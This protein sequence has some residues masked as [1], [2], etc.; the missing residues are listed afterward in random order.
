[1]YNVTFESCLDL[2]IPDLFQMV[3]PLNPLVVFHRDT[4]VIIVNGV[5]LFHHVVI[6]CEC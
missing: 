4:D 1:M 6:F 2:C 3:M 5:V